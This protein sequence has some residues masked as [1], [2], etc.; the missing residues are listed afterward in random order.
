MIIDIIQTKTSFDME[1]KIKEKD[2][3]I[4]IATSPFE[5]G[6]F[7]INIKYNHEI[8]QRLYYNPS[9][10]TWGKTL[11]DRL[12]FKL[13]EENDYCGRIVGKTKKISLLKA[14]AYYEFIYKDE[15]YYAYEVGFGKNG[16]YLCIYRGEE[17][18][19]M[20]DKS[21]KVINFQDTYRAYLTDSEDLNVVVPFTLYYDASSYGDVMEIAVLSIKEKRVV[22]IQK[23]LIAKYDPTFISRIKQMEEVKE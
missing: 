18:I 3:D 21:L 23:E 15:I 11:L 4:A 16:L 7:Q 19:A 14:Y 22:T 13:F 12:S 5:N 6:R 1:W 10:K 9:D 17:I 8:F 20:V 2:A